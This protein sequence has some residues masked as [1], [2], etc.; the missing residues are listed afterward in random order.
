MSYNYQC[1]MI[2]NKTNFLLSALSIFINVQFAFS[3]NDFKTLSFSVELHGLHFNDKIDYKPDCE[4]QTPF[5]RAT[6]HSIEVVS[7]DYKGETYWGN[8]LIGISFPI[9]DTEANLDIVTDIEIAG[10]FGVTERYELKKG[11]LSTTMG[12][13]GSAFMADEFRVTD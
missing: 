6:L 3:H 5:V 1:G 7:F 13:R 10:R 2:F 8:T 12:G 11:F 4:H 9:K